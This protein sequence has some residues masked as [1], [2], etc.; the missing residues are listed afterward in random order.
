MSSTVVPKFISCN[1]IRTVVSAMRPVRCWS[2][3][4][5]PPVVMEPLLKAAWE[6]LKP[7]LR[8]WVSSPF[9]L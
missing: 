9:S 3:A 4:W 1:G 8:P 2:W 5:P 7:R 6:T